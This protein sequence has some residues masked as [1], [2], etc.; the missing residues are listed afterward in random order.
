MS[1]DCFGHAVNKAIF[2]YNVDQM[3]IPP[4]GIHACLKL[5][6]SVKFYVDLAYHSLHYNYFLLSHFFVLLLLKL[7]G[8]IK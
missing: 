1:I 3:T 8:R 2:E 7:A 5:K 6:C 4:Y